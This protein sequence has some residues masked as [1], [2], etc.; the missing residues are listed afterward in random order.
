M[1]VFPRFLIFLLFIPVPGSSQMLHEIWRTDKVFHSPES[2]LFDAE[3][4]LIY[5]SNINGSP[6]EKDGNG[7]LSKL[8]QDGTV[9]QL[10]W[11]TGLHAPK[12]MAV[13]NHRLYVADIDTLV[14]I[15]L[16]RGVII[17]R[18]HAPGAVFLNDVAAASDGSIYVSDSRINKI[19]RLK[20]DRF[21]LWLE[22]SSFH[23]INGL[24][25]EK[26]YLYAGSSL[27][28]RN[29]GHQRK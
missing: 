13:Y 14:E 18:H 3:T 5:V 7:Y 9:I 16:Q 2:V 28:Q 17:K 21:T 29:T 10:Q 19:F 26:K 1:Y 4:G 15:D 24:Y 25:A 22:D 27:I 23:R 12:G 6:A 20:K 11:L 8:R